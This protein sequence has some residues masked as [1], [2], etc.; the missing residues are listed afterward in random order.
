MS[1]GKKKFNRYQRPVTEIQEA[2]LSNTL[3][4]GVCR[5]LTYQQ[6]LSIHLRSRQLAK[7]SRH[8]NSG[9]SDTEFSRQV[10]RCY[11][12]RSS[13]KDIRAQQES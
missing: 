3:E 10:D 1:K 7:E 11:Y 6:A 9:L 5:E 2:A 8:R 4:N 13:G 12:Q